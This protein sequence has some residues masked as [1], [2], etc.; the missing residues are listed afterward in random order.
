MVLEYDQGGLRAP[1]I[2]ALAKSLKLAWISRLKA[3]EQKHSE[4]WKAIPSDIFGKYGGLSF[5]LRCNYDKF[6]FNRLRYLSFTNRSSSI[7]GN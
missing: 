5:I 2:D 7:F 1:R 6:F 4:S 3:G